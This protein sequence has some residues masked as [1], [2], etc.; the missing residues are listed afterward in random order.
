MGKS[1]DVNGHF[2]RFEEMA[3]GMNLVGFC[4]DEF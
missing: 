2:L 3:M 4:F 1:W